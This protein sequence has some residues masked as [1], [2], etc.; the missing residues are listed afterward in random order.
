MTSVKKVPHL[1]AAERAARGKAARAAASRSRQGAWEPAADRPDVVDLLEEQ[2]ASRVPE[3]VPLRYGRMLVSPFTFFRGAAY[4]MAADLAGEPRTGLTVQLCGDAHLSNFGAFAAPDRRMVFGLNDFD[5]TL[6]GPFE[7]DVKRLAASFAVAG[8]DRQFSAKQRAVVNRTVVQGYRD[9]MQRLAGMPNLDL[10]YDRIHLEEIAELAMAQGTAKQRKRFE[11]NAAKAQ[12]KDNMRALGKLTTE[13]DGEPR[14]ISDP[15]LIVPIEE[16]AAGVAEEE[17]EQFLRG[18]L[19]SYRRTLTTDRRHLLEQFRYVHAARKVVGVGSVGT[20]AWV[21]LMLGRDASDPLFLQLKEAQPSVLEP[22]LGKS[23]FP[24]HGQRVV[25]G[26]RLTQ[27]AT[28]IMLGWIQVTAPDGVARDFYVRQLWDGK[29]SALVELMDPNAMT[30]YA[31]LCGQALAKAH[32]R[33]GDA[34]AI[35]AYLGTGDTFDRAMST[36]AE[37]YADQNERDYDALRAAVASGRV[38]A[39]SPA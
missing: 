36:F 13:V 39:E 23:K 34:I 17:I 33:S 27:A 5:E 21:V 28:D 26:Q 10:W 24:K 1:T 35:S 25:E 12:S 37:T 31:Q 29:G 15:P 30:F 9:E 19:R 4:P 8:R 38:T 20:R 11:R 2:A 22:F 7:W 18:V 6:P 3:L 32:A 16:I 14:I